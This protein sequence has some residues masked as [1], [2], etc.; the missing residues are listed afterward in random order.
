VN[1]KRNKFNVEAGQTW[2]DNDER[3]K[4]QRTFEVLSVDLDYYPGGRAECRLIGDPTKPGQ[5]TTFF[6]RLARFNGNKRGYS[7]ISGTA[8]ATSDKKGGKKTKAKA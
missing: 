3:V 7:L 5:R 8:A 2:Q 1:D 4:P 6:A